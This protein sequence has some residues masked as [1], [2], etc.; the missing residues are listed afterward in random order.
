MIKILSSSALF[1]IALFGSAALI[2]APA[3]AGSYKH[4]H[5]SW[6]KNAQNDSYRRHNHSYGRSYGFNTYRGPSYYGTRGY[7][8]GSPYNYYGSRP[9]FSITI[10]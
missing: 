7:Y 10:R 5:S 3:F 2:S 4:S 8:Y 1:A 9:G 6:N